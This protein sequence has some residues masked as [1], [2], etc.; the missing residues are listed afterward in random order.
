MSNND[1]IGEVGIAMRYLLV[2][3]E[4]S[5]L[6]RIKPFCGKQSAAEIISLPLETKDLYYTFK[7]LDLIKMGTAD[8]IYSLWVKPVF[9]FQ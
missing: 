7:H 9:Q 3:E 4:L 2:R 8:P 1:Q 5:R 6:E